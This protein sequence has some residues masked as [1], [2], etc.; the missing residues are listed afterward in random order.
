M[1]K[2]HYQEVLVEKV[3]ND[4]G[5]ATGY[6]TLKVVRE[7][8]LITDEQAETLNQGV[9]A[10]EDS[11]A[12]LYLKAPAKEKIKQPK[13]PVD[14]VDEH[15]ELIDMAD[16]TAKEINA[17]ETTVETKE[18]PGAVKTTGKKK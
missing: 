9:M 3:R 11:Q 13:I 16:E 4:K 2:Q 15:E 6:N 17:G 7:R 14:L 5:K 10:N 12:K 1:A 8:V 18:S